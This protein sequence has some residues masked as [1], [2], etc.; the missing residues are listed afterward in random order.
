MVAADLSIREERVKRCQEFVQYDFLLCRAVVF[1]LPVK[2]WTILSV[3]SLAAYSYRIRIVTSNM[4][5]FEIHGA[6]V[7]EGAVS[8]DV[9]M[10]AGVGAEASVLMICDEAID[11]IVLRGSGVGDVQDDEVNLP[12]RSL[13]VRTQQGQQFRL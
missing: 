13:Q 4:T 7:V 6:R 12:R 1:I 3:S 8:L 10:V 2:R 5:A 11:G 9:E